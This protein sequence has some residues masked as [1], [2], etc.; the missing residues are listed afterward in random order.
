MNSPFF[1]QFELGRAQ[2]Q[3]AESWANRPASSLVGAET[4]SCNAIA[5]PGRRHLLKRGFANAANRHGFERA[6]RP[7][8]PNIRSKTCWSG[9]LRGYR[10]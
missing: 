4:A 1:L 8:W 2:A 3:L 5:P 7:G 10:L 9:L 6:R